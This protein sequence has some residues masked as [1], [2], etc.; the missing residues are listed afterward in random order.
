MNNKVKSLGIDI[1]R[2]HQEKWAKSGLSQAKYCEEAGIRVSA[3]CYWRSRILSE[4]SVASETLRF[5]SAESVQTVEKPHLTPS[6]QM[7][8]PNGLRIG[9]DNRVSISLLNHVLSFAR[10]F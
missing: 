4:E 3:F 8:L 6:I 9:I 7:A 5:S 2:D 1:W 10:R